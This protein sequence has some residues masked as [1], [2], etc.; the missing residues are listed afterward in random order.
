MRNCPSLDRHLYGGAEGGRDRDAGQR[1][2]A[3]GRAAPRRSTLTEPKL[4]IA[5][6]P[7]AE[8][9][10]ATGLGCDGRHAADRA[11]DR[12]GAGALARARRRGRAAGESRPEDDATILF[13][14]GS[15]GVAKGAVSTH[16]AVT[17]GDLH[18]FDQPDHPARHHGER[19]PA[20]GQSAQHP[21]Q[22]AAVP[23]HRRGAG[24]A[25]QLRHRPRHGA[26]G[27]MGCRARR[28]G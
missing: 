26:D 16:R 28:C 20:A 12:R 23:R 8:R 3:A 21:G 15:T 5:D 14:S 1:L 6:A 10:E 18:L 27:E 13:T 9:L 19:G 7:R 11:A 24:D 25:Q 22:R 2:V 17:S 4:V